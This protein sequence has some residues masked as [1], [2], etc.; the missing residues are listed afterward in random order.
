VPAFVTLRAKVGVGLVSKVAVT[1]F[2]ASIV[3]VQVPVPVQAPAQPIKL[4]PAEDVA[5][6]VTLAPCKKLEVQVA[7]QSTPAGLLEML[8]VPVPDF[9]IVSANLGIRLKLAVTVFAASIVTLQVV[10]PVQAPVQPAKLEPA[11]ATAVNT[12]TVF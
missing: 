11:S 3:T 2:T 7:P 8:P 4:E 10:K 12:T 1:F 9:V 6:K 5:V